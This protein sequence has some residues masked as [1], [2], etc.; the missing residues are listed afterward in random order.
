MFQ[1]KDI[2]KFGN[3]NAQPTMGIAARAAVDALASRWCPMSTGQNNH[4]SNVP[5]ENYYYELLQ[6]PFLH[7]IL[8]VVIFG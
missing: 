8:S 2:E 7:H 4:K 3:T 1:S 6:C 5:P